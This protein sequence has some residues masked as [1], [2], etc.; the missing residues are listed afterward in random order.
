MSYLLVMGVCG[1]GKS[2]VGQAV[3]RGL[4][5]AFIE[6]DAYHSAEAR[7]RMGAGHPLADEDRWE[8]LDRIAQAALTAPVPVVLA[9]SALKRAYRDRLAARLRPMCIVH[10]V[11]PRPVLAARMAARR[12]HYMPE[13]LLDSQFADLQ[14]PSGPS[15]VTL[16]V[17][18]DLD[19]VVAE[20][21][22]F[23]TTGPCASGTDQV[24]TKGGTS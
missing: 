7:A 22:A 17:T 9:C 2:T 11:G 14:P 5:A 16:D 19:R 3:A 24:S 6:G 8:W 1:T 21:T 18:L 15:V 23:A 10:L 20:A 12:D 4:G 13:S